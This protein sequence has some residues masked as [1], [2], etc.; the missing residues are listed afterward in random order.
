MI[1]T[2]KAVFKCPKTGEEVSLHKECTNINGKGDNCPHYQ[3]WTWQGSHPLLACNYLEFERYQ[4]DVK[5]MLPED[6]DKEN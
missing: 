6:K 3:H 2:G 5:K 1:I 4:K